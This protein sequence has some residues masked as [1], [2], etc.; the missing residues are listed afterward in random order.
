MKVSRLVS[1]LK[2]FY[3]IFIVSPKAWYLPK[4][5][6]ILIYDA[7]DA[8]GAEAM[9]P[10]MTEY[11][12]TT[13]AVRGELMEFDPGNTCFVTLLGQLLPKSEAQHVN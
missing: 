3:Q 9:L 2:V 6:E 7:Y 11:R 10:Y 4:K 1:K 12:V 13:M 8:C 5:A